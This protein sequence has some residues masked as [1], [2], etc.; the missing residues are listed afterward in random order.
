MEKIFMA[1]C[2]ILIASWVMRGN[3][4]LVRTGEQQASGQDKYREIDGTIREGETLFDVFE[5]WK[6]DT[7]DLFKMKEAAASVHRLR[8]V[9]PGQPYTIVFDDSGVRSFDYRID[10]DSILC[11]TRREDRFCAARKAVKYEKRIEDISG[12]IEDNLVSSLGG[13]RDNLLLAL[14][15]SDIF[16]WDID[17]TT[18]LRKGDVF[19]VVVEGLYRNGEFRKYGDVLSAE[20]VNNGEVFRAYRYEQG[21]A[22]AYYDAEGRSL[23]KAILKAPL[24]FRRISSGFS[25]GRFHPILKTYRP[26]HGLD[27]AAPS[28]TPVSAVGDGKIVFAGHKGQFGNLVIIR[29]PNGW[30]TYYGHLSNI[31]KGIRRGGTVG[32]GVVIGRVGATGLATGPHLH[33]EVRIANRPVNPLALKLARGGSVPK[34][35]MTEFEHFKSSMDIRLASMATP[36]LAF[37]GKTNK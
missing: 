26:H 16:S 33:Y 31:G 15:M 36:V 14:Q 17:F 32:Q 35:Y 34:M 4:S 21:G 27:Y 29:H 24:S 2:I 6:L 22:A 7:G 10:D 30:K 18:D 28:G 9:Q 3:L 8:E 5:K 20:F 1:V 19:K 37:A 13:T 12:V 23:R 25:R 11:I